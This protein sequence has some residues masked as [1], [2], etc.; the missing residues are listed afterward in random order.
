MAQF[1]DEFRSQEAAARKQ[2]DGLQDCL[3]DSQAKYRRLQAD[4]EQTTEA[5]R[6]QELFLRSIY[7][8]V[9]EAI[10]VVDVLPDGDFRY[11]G[12][13]PAS[14]R[15]TGLS[16]DRVIGKAPEDILPAA[17]AG[18]VRS[19]Y[20][21]CLDQGKTIEYEEKLPF[22]GKETWWLTVLTPLREAAAIHRIIGVS[23]NI[24]ERKQME[25]R[26]AAL[27]Q[28]LEARVAAR[29]AE[30]EVANQLKD[31]LLQRERHAKAEIEAARQALSLSEQR[32][33][34]VVDNVR[35][36]IFQTDV[37]GCWTF[38]NA[39]WQTVSGFSLA[40]SLGQPFWQYFH[41]ED[42]PWC[43][44]RLQQVNQ[45]DL[46]QRREVR[47]QTQTGDLR[48]VEIDIQ[49]N[50]DESATFT[51]AVGVINDISDRRHAQEMLESR[52]NELTQINTLLLQTTALLE[53]RNQELDQFAYVASHDLKAPLRAIANLSTWLEEDLGDQLPA[54]SQE[55]MRLMRGRVHR[56]E[57]LIEGLLAYSRI[58]R[59]EVPTETFSLQELLEEII[60]SQAPPE[61]CDIHLQP[62]LP[63]LTTK[64]LILRQIFSNLLS[65]AIKYNDKPQIEVT[66]QC[67][68]RGEH[69]EFAVSDNGPGI[70]PQYH[71]K[72]F[73]V[74]QTLE[75]R[76]KTESTGIGL[77]IIKKIIDTE[78]EVITVD[79]QLGQG[80][81]FR[82][83]WSKQH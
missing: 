18:A 13:N 61:N 32:Y 53:R 69:Y 29:T 20:Q 51:G 63:T 24:T 73:Q 37:D 15:L 45:V 1:S 23:L 46:Q 57:A 40:E 54:E 55:H 25:V 21:A 70:S 42:Q 35:E 36:V 39:S 82:F 78:G 34:S 67:Q 10:F 72:I 12:F 80:S 64:R 9:R 79:S 3:V 8:N 81:T 33:R 17:A 56:M 83:T 22:S 76:D 75:A 59:K 47:L 4:H 49:P 58:G 68:D 43:R 41:V 66:I 74:F 62:D 44:D 30:L 38:L 11:A 28:D 60:D 19:R 7:N 71:E 16:A 65:N 52:A 27:N 26:L 48:W 2:L 50:Y 14:E 77:S 5:L 6:Q 31:T